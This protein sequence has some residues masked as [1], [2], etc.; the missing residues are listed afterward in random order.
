MNS[1]RDYDRLP[2]RIR[3]HRQ[4]DKRPIIIT[5]GPSD[6]RFLSGCLP[7]DIAYF[8]AGTRSTALDATESLHRANMQRFLSVV[9]RDFDDQVTSIEKLNIPIFPYENADL[10]GMLVLSPAFS[11]MLE[12]LGS[13]EKIAKQGGL[14]K[15]VDNIYNAV[16]PVSTLRR[17]NFEQQWGLKFDSV[18]LSSKI[19]PKTLTLKVQPYCAALSSTVNSKPSQSTLLAYANKIQ[20]NRLAPSCPRGSTPYLRGRDVLSV[21]GVALRGAIGSYPKAATE[22]EY[23]S[24]VLR[25]SAL[26][27]INKSKWGQDLSKKIG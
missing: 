5:E 6:V 4:V 25:L 12:E 15:V 11:R 21:T 9:D 20:S 19:D 23:L 24:K 7:L 1:I 17:A 13:A 14:S 16:H 26:H 8:P 27:Y 10:E 3:Q 22:V 18:D 2:D